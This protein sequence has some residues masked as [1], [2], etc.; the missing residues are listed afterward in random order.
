MLLQNKYSFVYLFSQPSGRLRILKYNVP[1]NGTIVYTKYRLQILFKF[2]KLIL[3]AQSA[4]R[5][6]LS[7]LTQRFFS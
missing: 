7:Q 3:S 6:P 4:Q 1:H 2:Y 5:P